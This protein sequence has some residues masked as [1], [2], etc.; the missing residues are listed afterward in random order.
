MK[1]EELLEKDGQIVYT[2]KGI[3]MLPWIHEGKDI[4]IIKK[5]ENDPKKYDSVFFKRPGAIGRGEYVLHRVMKDYKNGTYYIIGDNT[6]TGEIVKRENIYGILTSI[7]QPNRTIDVKDK[8]YLLKVK[9]WYLF[10]WPILYLYRS[11]KLI[12]QKIIFWDRIKKYIK[13]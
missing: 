9:L 3:S 4:M 13:K 7:K 6:R 8:N 2:N 10:I 5:L 11:F 1:F 12:V